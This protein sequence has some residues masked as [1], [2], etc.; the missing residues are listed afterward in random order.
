[1][2]ARPRPR[3]FTNYSRGINGII[4]DIANNG[5][6]THANISA[7]DFVF[8]VGNDQTPVELGRRHLPRPMCK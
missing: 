4:I 8:Y 5:G 7:S 2:A 3:N 1:M 6:G